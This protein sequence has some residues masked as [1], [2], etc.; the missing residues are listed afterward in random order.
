MNNINNIINFIDIYPHTCKNKKDF[1]STLNEFDSLIGLDSLKLF[2]Y[3]Q[4]QYYL[5]KKN[6]CFSNDN[7][8]YP[9]T[10]LLGPSGVGKTTIAKIIIKLWS[11]LD[12]FEEP[13]NINKNKK[14]RKRNLI[15]KSEDD[16]IFP[17]SDKYNA[18]RSNNFNIS[19]PLNNQNK[20]ILVNKTYNNVKTN[21]WINYHEILENEGEKEID[22]IFKNDVGPSEIKF[23]HILPKTLSFKS[24]NY[25]IP[26][27]N[28]FIKEELFENKPKN[29]DKFIFV[30]RADI[31]GEYIGH[32]A[33]KVKTLFN[34][35]QYI[36]IDEAYSL[37]QGNENDFGK[38]ALTEITN[39]LTDWKGVLILSGYPDKMK[40]MLKL[41]EGLSSRFGWFFEI[42]PYEPKNLFLI[43]LNQCSKYNFS[44]DKSIDYS[45]F[46]ER[47]Q[48]FDGNGRYI[49]NLVK[50]C[51]LVL[52]DDIWNKMI[53]SKKNTK[54]K[55]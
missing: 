15:T 27:S 41:N 6:G 20:V 43:F 22:N 46:K 9:H 13:Q 38:E 53:S 8:K 26:F 5:L 1:I 10:I 4:I 33:K 24:E 14:K 2:V 19:S 50:Q 30:S 12:I 35:Y 28:F 7:N 39:I 32:T 23:K 49:E 31:V 17:D 45:W 3:K 52:V 34:N 36:F 37:A 55:K 25:F 48:F 51:E 16:E 18:K 47:E 44:V 42:K 21:K 11:Y 29:N 40:E 54:K